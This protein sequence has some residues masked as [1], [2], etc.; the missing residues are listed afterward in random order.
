MRVKAFASV[1]FGERG[2][3]STDRLPPAMAS[4]TAAIS[5]KYLTMESKVLASC[6]ISS[7]P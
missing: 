4:E 3:T 5:F 2:W 6:P 7:L 1:S